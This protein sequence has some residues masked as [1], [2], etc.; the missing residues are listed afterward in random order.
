V[1]AGP[2][3]FLAMELVDGVTLTAWLREAPRTWREIVAIVAQAGRGLAAAHARGLV[4]RDFKPDNVLV[5]ATRARVADFGLAG[6]TDA[7][8]PGAHVDASCRMVRAT[9]SVSGTPA[10][11]AP[12]LVDGALPDARSDVFAFAVTLYEALH[13]HHPFAGTTVETMW[14]EMA[15]GRIRAG[16]NRVPA[17]LERSVRRGLAVDPAERWPDVASFVAAID[18]APRRRYIAAAALAGFAIAAGAAWLVAPAAGDECAAGATAAQQIWNPRARA[19]VTAQ[20]VGGARDGTIATTATRLVDRWSSSWA[21]QRRAA[22]N[23]VDHK[24]ARI[25]CL[26]RQLG[27]LGA[28]LDTW[29]AG[30]IGTAISAAASLPAPSACGTAADTGGNRAIGQLD[31][32]R[33]TDIKTLWRNGRDADAV[34]RLPAL[35]RDVEAHGDPD[36][37]ASALLIASMIEENTNAVEAAAIHA[38]RAATEASKA[39]DDA[40]LYA[41]LIQKA[42]TR[43]DAG[44]PA[45]ALGICDA[46]EALAVRGVPNPEKVWIARGGALLRL[47]RTPEAIAQYEKAIA[48]EQAQ[49]KTDPLAH[50]AL[51]VATAG[52]G[53][54]YL[55][56]RDPAR[57]AVEQKRA[58]ALQELDYGPRHPEIARTLHDLAQAEETL[59]DYTAADADFRHAR[60]ILAEAFGPHHP[61]VGEIDVA[62]A[63]IA[64]RTGHIDAARTQFEQARDELAGVLPANHQ[65]FF[66]V[67]GQL[68]SIE[69][70]AGRYAAALPHFERAKQILV[71]NHVAGDELARVDLNLASALHELHDLPKAKVAA[72]DVLDELARAGAADRER[73]MPW[74]LL[75]LIADERGDRA[76]AI[77]FARKVLAVTHDGDTGDAGISRTEIAAK[78]RAWGVK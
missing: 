52:L 48:H 42:Y 51:G 10:Y 53:N 1:V 16:A 70:Q 11:M 55:E 72:E 24:A 12:E 69:L 22:C 21:L 77:A 73:A 60:G 36:A 8:E 66:V 28:Q 37:F 35:L 49:A 43:I 65:I 74:A 20:L 23:A 3:P 57:A 45:D 26:E 14:L 6:L 34:P 39:G 56:S 27:E 2:E 7:A 59:H 31:A 30:S 9:A 15:A 78:M 50:I 5:D 25:G 47:G 18:R 19:V 38:T 40:L 68:G 67:E 62:L 4:H 61:E 46:A 33:I 17:W 76:A 44:E 32:A 58:L 13:G 64:A 54:A 71:A 75:A 41:A 63:T 29:A